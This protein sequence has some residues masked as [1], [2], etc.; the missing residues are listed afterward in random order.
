MHTSWIFDP[1][2]E[3]PTA[4]DRASR[5]VRLPSSDPDRAETRGLT[6]A[7]P[8]SPLRLPSRHLVATAGPTLP[9]AVQEEW[10]ARA[11]H[12]IRVPS[13]RAPHLSS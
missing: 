9:S 8:P 4:R 10:A 7:S 1:L 2:R 13:G 3:R 12:R 5:A 11:A 6:E